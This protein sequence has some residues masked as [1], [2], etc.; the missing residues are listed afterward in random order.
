MRNKAT[1]AGLGL[2][3]GYL[4]VDVP[5]SLAN[6]PRCQTEGCLG[7]IRYSQNACSA[8]RASSPFKRS[9]EGYIA[10]AL[11]RAAKALSR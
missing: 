10:K 7:M 4:L 11:F 5:V 8:K 1:K 9:S 6:L 3:N 2:R